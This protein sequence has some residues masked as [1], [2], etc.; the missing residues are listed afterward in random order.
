[1]RDVPFYEEASMKNILSHPSILDSSENV[2][3]RRGFI[4]GLAAFLASAVLLPQK[5][6]TQAANLTSALHDIYNRNRSTAELSIDVVVANLEKGYG[7]AAKKKTFSG[8][9]GKTINGII[10]S[11]GRCFADCSGNGSFATDDYD[12]KGAVDAIRQKIGATPAIVAGHEQIDIAAM[13]QSMPSLDQQKSY[14]LSQTAQLFAQA[15]LVA[16]KSSV[17]NQTRVKNTME[18][19]LSCLREERQLTDKLKAISFVATSEAGI[20]TASDEQERL[21]GL[22]RSLRTQRVLPLLSDLA[23]FIRSGTWTQ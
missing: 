16:E 6:W 17:A 13:K 15:R 23:Q 18:K 4:A 12:F 7:L 1:M 14:P 22:I 21:F 9:G 3:T 19:F 20:R 8:H 11:D 10:I 5:A 2:L